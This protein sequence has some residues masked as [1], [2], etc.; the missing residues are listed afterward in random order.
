MPLVI[1]RVIISEEWRLIGMNCPKCLK[2]IPDDALLCCYCGKR[3]QQD[4]NRKKKEKRPNGTGNVYK[5]GETWTARVVDHY[6]TV[7][8][9]DEKIVRPV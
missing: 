5:R 7:E 3:I 9:D 8:V 1:N 4:P 2:L 6:V